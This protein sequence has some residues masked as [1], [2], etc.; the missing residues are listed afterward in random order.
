MVVVPGAG[1]WGGGRRS[2]VR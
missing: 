2:K 1:K